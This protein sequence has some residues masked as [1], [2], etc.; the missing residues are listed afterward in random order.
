MA[1]IAFAGTLYPDKSFTLGAI[2]REKI[3][4]EDKQY[5]HD[6]EQQEEWDENAKIDWLVG[7]NSVGGKFVS[8][9]ESPLFINGLKS[10]R[11]FRGNYG[12]HGIT[13]FGRKF[14]KNGSL[15]LEQ[16]FGR[17]RL[18]F[19]TCTIPS[20]PEELHKRLNGKWGEVVRRFFQKLKRQ[21][22]KI[23]KPLIYISVSEIQEKR[24]HNSG[25]PAPHLHFVY[26]CRSSRNSRY[27]LYICQIHRAWNAA[28]RE[29]IALCGYPFTMSPLPGWGSVH[30]KTVRKSAGA[31]LGKYVSKGCKV[32]QEMK[33]AGWVEFPKQWWSTCRFCRTLFKNSLVKLTDSECKAIFYNY[34]H[35]L[36]EGWLKRVAVVTVEIGGEARTIGLAGEMSREMFDKFYDV[37]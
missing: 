15:L 17:R 27:W 35:Y 16:H 32:L 9:D 34:E 5:E 2:P 1:S 18:G 31:Y 22:A 28:V 33:E 4:R 3:R 30:A 23:S 29:G 20:L 6:L 12:T 11:E 19:V 26:V 13:S 36:H 7:T 21:L 8:K 10:S 24:F 37:W 14:V 25:I